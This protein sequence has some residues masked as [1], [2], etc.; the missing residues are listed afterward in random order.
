VT[1]AHQVRDPDYT[2]RVERSFAKQG[3]MD[4]IGATLLRVAPGEV[5]IALPVT[6]KVS[7]QH[8]FAHAGAVSTIADS[9]AG[10]AALT[11]MPPSAGVLTTEFK[12]NLMAP[13]SGERLI[14]SGR[15]VKA[16]R[17]LT[18]AQAEVHAEAGNERRLVALLTATL[19]TLEGRDGIAD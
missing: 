18:V 11:L 2:A 9:A 12:I 6:A 7:Q 13:A 14:A 4:T 8:G 3:I 1:G 5:D 19:M 16:G 17:T 10:Y 15:V